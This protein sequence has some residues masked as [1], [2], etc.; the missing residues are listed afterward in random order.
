MSYYSEASEFHEREQY[1]EAYKLYEQGANAGDEKCYYGIALFLYDG[2]Y[3]KE[4]KDAAAKIFAEHYDGILALAEAGDAEAMFI[5]ACYY[6]RGFY[7]DKD[8][9]KQ[10]KWLSKSAEHGYSQGQLYLG[11]M[12]ELGDMVEQDHRKAFELYQ[13]SA[14]QG[15]AMAQCCLASFYEYGTKGIEKDS[16]RAFRLYQAASNQG[17]SEGQV[18][19]G[20]MYE[21]GRGTEKDLN[22]AIELYGKSAQQNN[23]EA[24]WRLGH[25]Y[26]WGEG[27]EKNL[28]KA[29]ELYQ[30]SADQDDSVGQ[31]WL[32]TMYYRGK[33][34]DKNYQKAIE[35]YTKSAAQNDSDAQWSLGRIYEFGYGVR[36]DIDTA[37]YWYSR[38]AENHNSIGQTALASMY[39]DGTGVKQDFQRAV[40]LYTCAS[41]Q[42]YPPAHRKLGELYVCGTGVEK[43][44][45]Y[46]IDLFTN[47]VNAGHNLAIC[48]LG[49]AYE[50]EKNDFVQAKYWYEK[51]AEQNDSDCMYSLGHLYEK[52][53]GVEKSLSQAIELYH[54]ACEDKDDISE[55]AA[56]R[57]GYAYYDGEGVKQNKATALEYFQKAYDNGYPCSYAIDMLNNELNKNRKAADNPMRDYANNIISKN[58]PIKKMYPLVL[59]D[60]RKDFGPA[61][62]TLQLNSQKF[63]STSMVCYIALYSMGGH[64]YGNMDFTSCITP[65][66]KALETELGKYLYTGYINYLNENKIPVSAFKSKRSFIVLVGED[67]PYSTEF[68]YRDPDDL[69]HF[70]LGSL[71]LVIGMDRRTQGR[72][73]LIEITDTKTKRRESIMIDDGEFARSSIDQ[74][75]LDYAKSIFD[76]DAFGDVDLDR[77]ITDYL[78]DL[79]TEIKTITDSFRNPAAHANVMSYEKAETCANYLIKA[80]KLICKF[81]E[82]IKK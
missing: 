46:A 45:D 79:A 8:G 70:T 48:L 24:Q 55:Q 67:G 59:K 26:E 7:V 53:L 41:N 73:G 27:V 12:Y 18:C 34:V 19:L 3:V 81:V 21:L 77:A 74:T 44:I 31:F 65:M 35:W 42:G 16:D 40:E 51:G 22:K 71:H 1:E 49:I 58:L 61:W 37:I 32:A 75:M 36:K 56:Y 52:G 15:N 63:L 14:A 69:E 13:Y 9:S 38:S 60:L 39:E 76:E 78:V 72:K 43:N 80:K 33:G 68:T 6:T 4:D 28:V 50:E 23:S 30:V 20:R 17:H 54:K 57:L 2:Y 64:I 82:K 62:E 25:L 47:A 10:V 5:I 11:V 66:F 29:F